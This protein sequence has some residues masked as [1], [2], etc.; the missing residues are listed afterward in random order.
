MNILEIVSKTGPLSK[1]RVDNTRVTGIL[2][3][4]NFRR[5]IF[6]VKSREV[7][8]DPDGHLISVFYPRVPFEA[9]EQGTLKRS[10]RPVTADVRIWCTCPAWQMWGSAFI[11]TKHGYNLPRMT[12][13]RAPNIRDPKQ[14]NF[15]CKHVIRVS[16]KLE[17]MGF[18]SLYESFKFR[19]VRRVTR[20][21][22][23]LPPTEILEMESWDNSLGCVKK[24][25]LSNTEYSESQATEFL[26]SLNAETYED[27]L[28]ELGVFGPKELYE[29]GN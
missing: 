15:C 5:F 22:I 28:A 24:W 8:S 20:A 4:S 3:R 16:K 9:I 2:T 18:S 10:V 11:S 23:I 17:R 12:E 14:Q 13:H 27:S 29:D 19:D 26:S 1:K 7:Y 25:M 6:R 21:N